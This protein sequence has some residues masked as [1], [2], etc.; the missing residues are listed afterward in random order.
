MSAAGFHP[1]F[2]VLGGE[3]GGVVGVGV[4]LVIP[5]AGFVEDG[6]VD[7]EGDDALGGGWCVGHVDGLSRWHV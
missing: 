2:D 3:V 6:T 1:L 4:A 5:C 7:A